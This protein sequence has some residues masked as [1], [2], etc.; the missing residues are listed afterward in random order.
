MNPRALFTALVL[1]A[2]SLAFWEWL[3]IVGLVL[4]MHLTV[5]MVSQTRE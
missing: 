5:W 4:V 3:A 1:A 2:A